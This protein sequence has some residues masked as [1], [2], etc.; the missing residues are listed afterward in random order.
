M[1]TNIALEVDFKS[2]TFKFDNLPAH[3]F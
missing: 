2:R 1:N 3:P